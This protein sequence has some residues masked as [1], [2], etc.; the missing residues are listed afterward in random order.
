MGRFKYSLGVIIG[1]LSA[2][3]LLRLL[4]GA[5]SHFYP[6][7]SWYTDDDLMNAE[8]TKQALATMPSGYFVSELI[9]YAIVSYLA[10]ITATFISGRDKAWPS[11][12][13]GA[14]LFGAGLWDI[15]RLAE[16]IGFLAGSFFAFIPFAWYG[17]YCVRIRQTGNETNL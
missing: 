1:T 2:L 10:G 11:V 13:S 8:K 9:I 3:A 15:I 14:I 5:N 12:M 16:P 4:E 6:Y 7:P 17:Y